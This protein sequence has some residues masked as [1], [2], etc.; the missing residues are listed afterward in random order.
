MPI[1]VL[2]T[3][4]D[5]SSWEGNSHPGDYH[6][7]QGDNCRKQQGA[8][9]QW[10]HTV[11]IVQCEIDFYVNFIRKESQKCLK[12]CCVKYCECI[13]NVLYDEERLL[14]PDTL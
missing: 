13:H 9:M 8:A 10:H 3:D 2:L 12:C 4:V 14:P 5:V 7:Q 1:L 6:R 11:G